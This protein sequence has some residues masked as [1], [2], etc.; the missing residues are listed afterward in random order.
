MTNVHRFL[1][2]GR[3]VGIVTTAL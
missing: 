1:M 2:L 3:V